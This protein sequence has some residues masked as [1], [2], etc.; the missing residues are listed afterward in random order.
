MKKFLPKTKNN[1]SGFTLIELMIVITIIA[2]LSVI[3]V[4]VY[5]GVQKNARDARRKGDVDSIANALEAHY[6]PAAAATAVYPVLDKT[7]FAAGAIPTDPDVANPYTLPSAAAGS[8]VVCAKLENANGNY[9]D[10]GTTG[11]TGA[12]A[13]YYCKKNSQ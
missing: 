2:V 7:W 4:T 10:A 11:A 8:F 13:T 6:N 9:S 12:A 3:G 1:T 5:T